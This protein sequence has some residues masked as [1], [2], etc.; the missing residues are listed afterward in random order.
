MGTADHG[1]PTRVYAPGGVQP[2]PAMLYF[3]GGGHVKGGFAERR[4]AARRTLA[5]A[6]SCCSASV[7]Q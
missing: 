3:H 1:G 5:W 7:T 2:L 4:Y 6:G